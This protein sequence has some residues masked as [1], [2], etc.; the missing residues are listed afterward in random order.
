M[1]YLI[2]VRHA[3]SDWSIP[4]LN[5]IDRP[6]NERGYQSAYLMSTLLQKQKIFLD[7]IY[8]SPAVRA[9]TTALI[10]K[11]TFKLKTSNFHI[12][13]TIYESSAQKLVQLV[14][15]FDNTD[16]TCM[17]F[18]HNPSFTELFNELAS[19]SILN[20]P[21][22]GCA[23]LKFNIASWA[24]IKHAKAEVVFYSAPKNAINQTK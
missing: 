12:E 23:V 19:E 21:T 11:R 20:M 3:K 18:G 1:K 17:L 8:T 24:E 14:S 22:C 13:E 9:I 6:L 5:D 4:A 16:S 15:R 10:F 2:L 7:A